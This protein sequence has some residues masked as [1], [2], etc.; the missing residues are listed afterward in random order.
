MPL[1]QW[2]CSLP[3]RLRTALA[4]D[5]ELCADVLGAFVAAL[6]LDELTRDTVVVAHG[7][8]ARVLLVILGHL[9]I[10]TAPRL[11]IRQGSILVI[12]PKG[13]RWA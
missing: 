7:G 6:H 8:V 5:R 12:E 9:D 2:V 3:W 1:R 13:W 4:Y 11:G 10:Y